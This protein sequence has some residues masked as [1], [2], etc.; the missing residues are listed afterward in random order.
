MIRKYIMKYIIDR[1]EGEFAVL[2]KEEGGTFDVP[3][4]QIKDAKE[5][6]VVLFDD[7]VYIIDAEETEKRKAMI[8]EKMRKLFERE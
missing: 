4:T 8:E 2:E 7:G 1:F 6:D 3:K 5:G